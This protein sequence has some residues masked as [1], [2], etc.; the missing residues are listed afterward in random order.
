MTDYVISRLLGAVNV[1]ELH[2]VQ[3]M[4]QS[5]TRLQLKFHI[6]FVDVRMYF[7][8]SSHVIFTSYHTLIYTNGETSQNWMVIFGIVEVK[9]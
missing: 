9:R 6:S 2:L 8:P 4:G 3:W 5:H 7:L 1:I